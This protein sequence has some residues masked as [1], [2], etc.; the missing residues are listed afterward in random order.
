M[1]EYATGIAFLP[2]DDADATAVEVEKV[3]VDEGFTVLGWRDGA[4]RGRRARRQRTRG[5]ARVPP[6]V[7]RQERPRRATTLER[8]VYAARKRIEHDDRRVLP[9][10]LGAGRRLQGHAHARAARSRSTATCRTSGSSPRSCLVHSRFSTNTFPS[11][12]ARAPVPDARPQRRDQH[13]AG[14]RELD[15]RTRRRDAER[16]AP[17]AART[18]LPD[19]HARRVRHRALRRSA[20]AAEHGRPAA[21]P[22]DPDD[23][24]GG[25]GEP[26]V[27]GRRRARRSTATTRR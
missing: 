14:Q 20:R 11:L 16:R 3:L 2:P 26:R 13:R 7:R 10:A 21:A 9:V 4:D 17:R 22:R 23:D 15:A 19:L 18:H 25:V 24:P 12:A 8:H 5:A 27:D 6:G 1:G